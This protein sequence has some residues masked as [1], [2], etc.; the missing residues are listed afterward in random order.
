MSA[1]MKFKN[2]LL[3]KKRQLLENKTMKLDAS[4]SAIIQK[5][6]PPNSKDPDSFNLPITIE[7]LPTGKTLLN[8]GA[9][10]NL[11]SLSMTRKISNLEIRL[12]WISLQLADRSVKYPHVVVEDVLV[13]VDKF[14]FIADF[15]ILDIDE[16][17][18]MPLI[19]GRKLIVKVE[20]VELTFNVFEDMHQPNNK[21]YCFSLDVIDEEV[22]D[23]GPEE[24]SALSNDV[25]EGDVELIPV[26]KLK[27]KTLPSHLKCAFLEGNEEKPVITSSSLSDREEE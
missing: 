20:D 9:S 10:I 26:N 4:C 7:N 6:I 13:R 21:G 23:F 14:V 22:L 24:V 15:I 5:F 8:L 19:L 11:M 12:T 16:D 18:D 2:E 1:Y 25:E 17:I 3:T 27:L